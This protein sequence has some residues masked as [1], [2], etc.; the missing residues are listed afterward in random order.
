MSTLRSLSLG[1]GLAVSAGAVYLMYPATSVVAAGRVAIAADSNFDEVPPVVEDLHITPISKDPEG[2]ALL[3][4]TYAKGQEL[5]ATIAFNAGDTPVQLIRDDKDPQLYSAKIPFDFDGLVKQQEERQKA[6]G[7]KETVPLFD[8]REFLGEELV[9]FLDPNKLR[10]QIA[11]GASIRIPLVVLPWPSLRV[12]PERSLLITDT[13]VVED[14]T[15]TFDACTGV[16]NPNGAWTFKRLMTNMANPGATG[17]DPSDFV[18]NWMRTWGTSTTINTFPVPARAQMISQVL[19]TWPRLS[20]GKLNLDLAP[21]RNL[22]IVN[23]MDLR[24]NGG[25]GGGNAGEGRFVFGMLRRNSNGTC[26]VLPAT[27]ILEYAQTATGCTGVRSLAQQWGGLGS[28]TLGSATYNAALQ[29]LTDQ[30]T[31]A[32]AAPRKPNGSAINQI[33]TNEFLQNPWELREFNVIRGSGQLAIVSAK[34]TPHNS[35]N[36]TSLLA[37]YINTFTPQIL[38]GTYTVPLSHA[39][40]PFLTG[41]VIN[42]SPQQVWRAPGIV[43]NNAR[44]KFSL[45]TCDACHG[46]ETLT[47]SF[48]HVAPRASGAQAALSRFLIGNGTLATPTTFSMADPIVSTQTRTYGDLLHRQG[49]LST[50]QNSVCSSSAVFQEAVFQPMLVAH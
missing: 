14:P 33:R 49:D 9:Q 40:Q 13:R 50:L 20:N 2:N 45:N 10:E 18:E 16:G 48:L 23:R 32:N 35:R 4:L 29:N 47:T 6:A 5:P 19:N 43:N 26:T 21:M 30:F 44:N 41:S 7:D 28:L 8:G 24:G 1:I 25:Y 34:Q 46:R 11:V 3:Q 31:A 39:G 12:R 38:A 37:N 22:A 27:V 36:N 42:P 17:I 15:R